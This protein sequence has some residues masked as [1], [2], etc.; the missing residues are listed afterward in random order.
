MCP[1]NT[2]SAA[3]APAG[4]PVLATR[5]PHAQARGRTERPWKWAKSRPFSPVSRVRPP[6]PG[7]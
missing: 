3:S 2:E 6:R 5:T 7:S 4:R 1:G